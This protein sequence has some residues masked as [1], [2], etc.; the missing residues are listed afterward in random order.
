MGG[1]DLLGVPPPVASMLVPHSQW[2]PHYGTGAHLCLE[3]ALLR[4]C[5]WSLHWV[6]S[7]HTRFYAGY[8]TYLIT[9]RATVCINK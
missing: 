8:N 9:L 6:C 3:P 5:A 1:L 2:G 4:K 7:P